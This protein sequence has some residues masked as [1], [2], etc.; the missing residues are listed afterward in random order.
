MM[1]RTVKHALDNLFG[2]PEI[3]H[4]EYM[5]STDDQNEETTPERQRLPAHE[6]K[7]YRLA[8]KRAREAADKQE[9]RAVKCED[10]DNAYSG[11]MTL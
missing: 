3:G 2:Q 8:C 4:E 7:S 5:P 9:L 11:V 10:P 1:N 6:L